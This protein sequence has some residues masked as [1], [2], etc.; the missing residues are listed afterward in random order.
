VLTPAAALAQ[1]QTAAPATNT[2][3]P[4]AAVVGEVVVTAQKRDEKLVDV[5]VSITALNGASMERAGV[6]SMND[7]SKVVPAMHIDAT[8]AFYQPSIRGVGTA[9]SGQGV[10]P[11]VA[12]YL[13]GIYQPNPLSNAFD[14]VDVETIQV[15]RG[16]Q[17]TLFGR[18][19]PA[20]AILVTTKSPTFS[21]QLI[22]SG[23]YGSFN[24]R[25]AAIF[26]SNKLTDKLA[27]SLAAG[28]SASDGWITNVADGSDANASNSYTVRAKLRYEPTDAIRLTLTGDV[29]RT[30]DP[31][32]YATATYRGFSDASL[33]FGVPVVSDNRRKIDLQPGTFRHQIAGSGVNLKGEFDLGFA[34]LISYTSA[35]REYGH[36]AANE[37]ASR[38]APDGTLPLQPCPTLLTCSYLATGAYNFL[39]A[40]SWKDVEQTYSQEIDLASKPGG[41]FDWV[42]GLY[43]F[44]DN[45]T[46]APEHLTIYGPFG[47][48]G[49]LTGALPPWPA[50][51]FVSLPF[52]YINKAAATGESR[53]IFADVT[54][55][56]GPWH[57]TV[58]G[59]LAQDIPGVEFSAPPNLANGF[60]DYPH[61]SASQ[62]FGSFTPRVVLRYSI[63]P[64]SNVYVSWSKGSKSAVY[65]ASGFGNERDVIQPE[66]VTDIE[67]GYKYSEGGTAVEVSAFHYDYKNLQAST[68]QNGIALIQNAPKSEMWGGDIQLR[69]QVTDNFRIEAGAAYTHARYVDFPNAVYQVF[70]PL[71]GVLNLSK[72]VSG[73]KM[74]RTPAFMGNVSATYTHDLANG[75]LE[76]NGNYAYQTEASFDFANTI[77]QKPY[78]LLTLRVSWTD[79]SRHWTIAGVA[80][81]LTDSSYLTQVLPDSGGFGSV[82]GEPR[83]FMVKLTYNY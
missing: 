46:Y 14:F 22:I 8:G 57:F 66:S 32:G 17:G 78:G 34:N 30:D 64:S 70:D 83:S 55:N 16:P 59:R 43:Y 76:I 15:L 9:V 60:V 63:N 73:G 25:E 12:T 50:G 21:P 42:T 29:E 79:P 68:Y 2:A 67:G 51:S 36:E 56:H 45:T 19:T 40:V 38:F 6:T 28:I 13:D 41:A 80:R 58:G 49:A 5:P 65:N 81:N 26:A 20:G 62:R 47:V 72:D 77:I 1:S 31:T 24:T 53:A 18:N 10:S 75:E 7:L 54:Y 11:S 44:H 52:L 37:S 27:F 74:E 69:Q 82:Y 48:G 4:G 23:G 61:L 3:L 39:E 33:F 71:R 35:H